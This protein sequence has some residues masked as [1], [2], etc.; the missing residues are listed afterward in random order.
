MTLAKHKGK[1]GLK[2]MKF[3]SQRPDKVILL[4]SQLR[5]GSRKEQNFKFPIHNS[6]G[7]RKFKSKK[8]SFFITH[9]GV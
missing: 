5:Y 7:W 2:G 9:L 4:N 3:L 1:C 6:G 8:R